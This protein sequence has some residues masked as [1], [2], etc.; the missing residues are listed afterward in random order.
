MVCVCVQKRAVTG[1]WGLET[2]AFFSI[3]LTTVAEGG[4]I[5]RLYASETH[6]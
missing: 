4:K 6:C 5:H 2:V 3:A 1:E